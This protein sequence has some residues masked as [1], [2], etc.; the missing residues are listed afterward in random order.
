M[1]PPR[2]AAVIT[3]CDLG[4][5]LLEALESVE[6]QTRPAA[7]IVVVD[8]ASTDIHTRQV[9]ARLEREGTRVARTDGRGASAARNG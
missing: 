2:I 7:E 6:R 9:L 4:R 1:T 5:L 3:C 8:D